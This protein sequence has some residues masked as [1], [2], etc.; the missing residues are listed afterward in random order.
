M[1]T[2]KP[3]IASGKT[4]YS[5]A[6]KV[7]A[8]GV[9]VGGIGL[10]KDKAVTHSSK[11]VVKGYPVPG[12]PRDGVSGGATYRTL[13]WE[14]SESDLSSPLA[15][16]NVV[17][18]GLAFTHDAKP[19]YIRV[20]I[21]GKLRKVSDRLRFAFPPRIHRDQGTTLTLVYLDSEYKAGPPLDSLARGLEVSM[22]RK[23]VGA[24][25]RELPD[26]RP[27]ELAGAHQS[28]EAAAEQA[29][30]ELSALHPGGLARRSTAEQLSAALS[31]FPISEKFDFE[32]ATRKRLFM[33]YSP[34]AMFFHVIS[35]FADLFRSTRDDPRS[36]Q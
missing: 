23:N 11:W 8:M 15:H 29:S 32:R 16:S 9:S 4:S 18:T 6:P 36:L 35:M 12:N 21:E 27:P 25:P 14:L 19:F 20:E 31:V 30:D 24:T 2:G 3:T 13:R 33:T 28:T 1:L 34:V 17:H 10:K 5:V 7:G 22:E 26:S